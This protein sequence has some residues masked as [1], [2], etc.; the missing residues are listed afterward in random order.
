MATLNHPRKA[1]TRD[2]LCLRWAGSPWKR[3]RSE[4]T[5]TGTGP[6][7]VDGP[8]QSPNGLRARAKAAPTWFSSFRCGIGLRQSSTMRGPTLEE[9]TSCA[10]TVS[11]WLSPVSYTHLRAHET[12][13]DLV[14]R[15]LLEKKK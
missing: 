14:C 13:H 4:P 5:R 3:R 9:R 6:A 8:S 15:L 1:V 2:G 12:R 11:V 10:G 7:T